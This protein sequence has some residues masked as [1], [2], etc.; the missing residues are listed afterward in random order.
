[1]N[2]NVNNY[3]AYLANSMRVSF[4]NNNFDDIFAILLNNMFAL[5]EKK[6]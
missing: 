3:F 4:G 2:M 6:D 1:M 5:N